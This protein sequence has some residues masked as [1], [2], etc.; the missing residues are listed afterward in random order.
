MPMKN[1]QKYCWLAMACLFLISSMSACTVI[2]IADYVVPKEP[3]NLPTDVVLK[4]PFYTQTDNFCGPAALAMVAAYHGIQTDIDELSKKVYTPKKGGSLQIEMQAAARSL[5]LVAFPTQLDLASLSLEIDSGHPVIILQNLSLNIYPVWHYSVVTGRDVN[6]LHFLLHSGKHQYY[7]SPWHTLRNTWERSNY[8]AMVMLPAGQLP[9]SISVN[10]ALQ[11]AVNLEQIGQYRLAQHTYQAIHQRW[12]DNFA[13]LAGVANTHMY[14]EE[15]LAASR[16]YRQAL[17]LNTQSAELLNNFAYTAEALGC[18][19]TAIEAVACALK[20]SH[21]GNPA[22]MDTLQQLE[23]KY[24][25][26]TNH[27]SCPVVNCS[28]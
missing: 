10:H 16:A 11:A 17:Q 3:Q 24:P 18:Q 12:P 14:L 22:I 26:P 9:S 7:R 15:P 19:I 25:Q 13:A 5:G 2:S 8:W 1:C 28:N 21:Q 23:A 4:V 27:N 20:M 6:R